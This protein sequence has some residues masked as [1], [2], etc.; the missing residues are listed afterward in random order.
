MPVG[1]AGCHLQGGAVDAA[2]LFVVEVDHALDGVAGLGEA[3]VHQ[4][5]GSCVVGGVGQP[6][7]NLGD[8]KVGQGSCEQEA[9]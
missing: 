8:G 5:P 1:Q 7:V 4:D 3:V 6:G 2:A 9:G